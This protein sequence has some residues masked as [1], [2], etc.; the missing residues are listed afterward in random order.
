MSGVTSNHT[1]IIDTVVTTERIDNALVG[2]KIST[3]QAVKRIISGN[4]NLLGVTPTVGIKLGC[5]DPVTE[6][7]KSIT[8][9]GANVPT[10]ATNINIGFSL[11]ATGLPVAVLLW[12]GTAAQFDG[13]TVLNNQASVGS[14]GMRVPLT[15]EKFISV[16]STGA[17]VTSIDS[18]LE[19][20]IEVA[21][22]PV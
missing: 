3:L 15:T 1:S 6:F 11:T 16:V 20:I 18:T 17:A 22:L 12:D 13:M 5:L 7:V 19:Y 9:R 21:L 10:G 8:L 14:F 4:V 2:S